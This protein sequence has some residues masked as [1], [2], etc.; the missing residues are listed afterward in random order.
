MWPSHIAVWAVPNR[1]D[2]D[3]L[4]SPATIVPVPLYAKSMVRCPVP[5][6]AQAAMH[7]V[8]Y[9][10]AT[11]AVIRDVFTLTEWTP[12]LSV[13][14]LFQV[15]VVELLFGTEKFVERLAT[16]NGRPSVSV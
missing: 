2:A 11:G 16:A 3:P 6:V 9:Q 1:D 7:H 15:T 14:L 13:M 12:A 8:R 5:L 4:S 10:P